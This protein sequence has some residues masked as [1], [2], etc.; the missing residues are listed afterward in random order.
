[1]LGLDRSTLTRWVKDG[2][3]QPAMTVPGY[4]GAYL[5]DPEAIREIVEERSIA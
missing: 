1:M 4:K 2:K 3:I 5:F